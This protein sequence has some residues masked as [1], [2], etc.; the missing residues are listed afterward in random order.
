[1]GSTKSEQ[2]RSDIGNQSDSQPAGQR[3]V[4]FREVPKDLSRVV[5]AGH[6]SESHAELHR[7]FHTEFERAKDVQRALF[8]P[9]GFAIPGLSVETFY[10]PA[11]CIGGD[12]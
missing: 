11:H 3:S 1:V 5:E 4:T 9:Q 10:Q 12:Y 2:T 8:P 6:P 7:A